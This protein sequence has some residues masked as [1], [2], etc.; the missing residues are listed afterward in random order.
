[1]QP[2]P[3]ASSSKLPSVAQVAPLAKLAAKGKATIAPLPRRPS[4]QSATPRRVSLVDAGHSPAH[5]VFKAS[6]TASVKGKEKASELD[7]L[8]DAALGNANLVVRDDV[9]LELAARIPLP[10]S[11]T[12]PSGLLDL[13]DYKGDDDEDDALL[14]DPLPPI[15]QTAVFSPPTSTFEYSVSLPFKHV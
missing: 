14:E 9:A 4:T 2:Q 11:P 5:S 7:I 12:K 13:G 15:P 8:A 3:V 6:L 1:M 10:S